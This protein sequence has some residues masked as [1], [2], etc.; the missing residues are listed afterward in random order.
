MIFFI[1][2]KIPLGNV[3]TQH[4]KST[5]LNRSDE[6]NERQI[7]KILNEITCGFQPS[8]P[9]PSV[10]ADVGKNTAIQCAHSN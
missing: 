2:N 8:D 10:R 5:D 1:K 4:D 3:Y 9:V 6:V 7:K